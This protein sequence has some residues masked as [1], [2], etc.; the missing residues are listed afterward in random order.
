MLRSMVFGFFG[1]FSV[2]G[3]VFGQ[4]F[5]YNQPVVEQG[6]QYAQY[7]TGG[8]YAPP[9]QQTQ[10]NV[11]QQVQQPVANPYAW[12]PAA[13]LQSPFQQ[14]QAD[15]YHRHDHYHHGQQQY[16][17]NYSYYYQQTPQTYYYVPQCQQQYYYYQYPHANR[18]WC[19]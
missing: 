19:W 11:N 17:Q 10:V 5:G 13:N 16:Y 7:S 3:L 2:A 15:M 6:Q 1:I 8:T 12:R 9:F 4:G 18:Y 14:R